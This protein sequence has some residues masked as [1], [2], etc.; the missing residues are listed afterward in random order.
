MHCFRRK[1]RQTNRDVFRAIR[2]WRAVLHPFTAM[3]NYRLTGRDV[4]RSPSVSHSQRTF[5]DQSEFVELRRLSR[6]NPT[7]RAAHVRDAQSRFGG[8]YPADKFIDEFW[9]VAGS[10]DARGSRN[11][12]WHGL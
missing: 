2:M 4:Q 7:A 10:G 12:F 11:K 3:S 9:F 6:L 5:E 8:I 1:S